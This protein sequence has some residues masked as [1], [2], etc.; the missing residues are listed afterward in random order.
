[1]KRLLILLMLFISI[2]VQGQSTIDHLGKIRMRY[3]NGGSPDTLLIQFSGDSVLYDANNPFHKFAGGVIM[4]SIKL[5]GVWEK[6]F[7]GSQWTTSGSNIYYNSGNVG[8]G[9]TNPQNKLTVS[10][11]S[12][13]LTEGDNSSFRVID[14]ENIDYI[15]INSSDNELLI[16]TLNNS[17]LVAIGKPNPIYKLDVNGLIGGS[18]IET[19]TTTKSVK[20]GINAGTLE[21]EA[22][23]LLNISIGDS[24]NYTN[25]TGTENVII[26]NKA[27][28]LNTVEGNVFVGSLSGT[29]NNN[30]TGNLFLGTYSGENNTSGSSNSF[31]GYSAGWTNTTGVNNVYLGNY[32]GYHETGSNKLFIDNQDRTDEATSRT[33]SLI[34]GEFNATPAS[35]LLRVNGQLESHNMETNLTTLSTR[36]GYQ[37]GNAED[38]TTYRFNTL[39]GLQSGFATTTGINNTF[40]GS[41]SGASNTT[42]YLNSFYGVSS[43]RGNT[44]GYNNTMIGVTSGYS[45]KYGYGNVY[46]GNEARYYGVKFNNELVI[47]NQKRGSSANDSLLVKKYAL[48]YGKF[49]ADTLNQELDINGRLRYT[50]TYAEIHVHDASATQTIPTGTTYTKLTCYTDN[51]ESS[52]CT[53]DAANDKITITKMGRYRV[54]A[55]SSTTVSSAAIFRFAAFLGGVEQ[56]DIHSMRRFPNNDIS[57][58]ILQGF[59]NVSSVPVDVD[60]RCRHDQGGNVDITIVYSNFN[61]EYIG[62]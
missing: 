31:I 17:I 49:D 33:S 60:I 10:G 43:G 8:I 1:M 35:Q 30:G 42:G 40:T 2:G 11:T 20:L 12:L 52:N 61:V 15:T 23:E 32:A 22:G 39:L 19:N 53:A 58:G 45:S 18:N 51:G 50:G 57:G 3:N 26:G 62:E 27:G 36:L 28:R 21:N 13:F 16:D 56:D 54:T 24:A 5:N 48:M 6:S 59:I 37:S 55:S 47:D 9:L 44:T 4:D 38:E 34:Y 46:I 14:D 7:V 41:Y 29:K 25:A